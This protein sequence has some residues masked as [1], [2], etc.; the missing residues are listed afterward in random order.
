MSPLVIPIL[1]AATSLQ[2]APA[3]TLRVQTAPQGA[4]GDSVAL[5][6][7]LR[8]GELDGPVERTFGR[9]GFVVVG[10]SEEI[11]V[12]DLMIPAIRVFD[13]EGGYLRTFGRA[14]QGPGEF[15]S[16]FGLHVSDDGVVSVWD[17]L[18]G[19]VTRLDLRGDSVLATL[20][21]D[22]RL[23]TSD[24]DAMRVT[25]SGAHLVKA[26][27]GPIAAPRPGQRPDIRVMAGTVWLRYSSSGSL[28]DTLAVPPP[29]LEGPGLRVQTAAGRIMAF[30]TETVSRLDP[31][32][33]LVWGRTDR[34]EIFRELGDGRILGMSRDFVPIPVSRGEKAQWR[35][36]LD[37]VGRHTEEVGDV[38][39]AFRDLW[40]D[41]E[42]RIWVWRYVESVHVP[43]PEAEKRGVPPMNWREPPTWDVFD[44]TG[45]FLGTVRLPMRGRPVAARGRD[46]WL[47]EAGEFGEQSVVRYRIRSLR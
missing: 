15:V 35:A 23:G 14:G 12:A 24:P 36:M 32:G 2:P 1:A 34:Y 46:L 9:I 28:P 37:L 30:S 11:L 8:V 31:D 13:A 33:R 45:V 6:P 16:I 3:N 44:I 38:K 18:A 5:D 29:R 47:V 42:G 20:P 21:V 17:P 43:D 41:D 7:V 27:A 4:W 25:R 10:P 39:P 40:I 26:P 19:R 22:S